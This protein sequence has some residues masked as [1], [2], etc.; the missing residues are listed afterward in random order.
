MDGGKVFVR[1]VSGEQ[2]RRWHLRKAEP[3][4]EGK[5]LRGGQ[6]DRDDLIWGWHG[7]LPLLT[8]AIMQ[9]K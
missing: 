1:A 4:Q 6:V 2:L 5:P 9:N 3:Q 8:R 7:W